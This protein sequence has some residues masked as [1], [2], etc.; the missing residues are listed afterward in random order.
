MASGPTE[1]NTPLQAVPRKMQ[2]RV[3]SDGTLWVRA[4]IYAELLGGRAEIEDDGKL[5]VICIEERCIPIPTGTEAEVIGGK[6]YAR[7]DRLMQALGVAAAPK[8]GVGLGPGDAAP[9]FTLESLDGEPVSLSDYRGQKVLV[10]AW[11][12]W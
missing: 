11:A 7:V 2:V 5:V 1:T 9:D 6:P 8:R 4:D 12:S 10:F 3:K